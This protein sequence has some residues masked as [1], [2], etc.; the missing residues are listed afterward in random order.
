[1]YDLIEAALEIAADRGARYADGRVIDRRTENVSVRN[2]AVDALEDTVSSGIGLR[3]LVDGGWGFASTREL[4]RQAIV[5]ATERAIE[6]ARAS[7]TVRGDPVELGDPVESV[8][9]FETPVEIHPFDISLDS[10]LELLLQADQ[11]AQQR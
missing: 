11:Q 2:G 4:E 1:M 8:G 7:D 6:I 10:K 5:E 3:V 9:T